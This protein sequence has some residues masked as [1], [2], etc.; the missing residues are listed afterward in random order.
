MSKIDKPSKSRQSIPLRT[1]IKVSVDLLDLDD[2]NPRLTDMEVRGS[3]EK[4]IA[5][6]YR[7][8]DLNELL[9]SI[10]ANGYT[11]IEPFIV[12]ENNDRYIVLEGNRRLA[13]VRL[14]RDPGLSN[15]VFE[16]TGIRIRVPEIPQRYKD[17]L[18]QISVYRVTERKDADSFIGFKHING[19]ARWSSY[20]KAKFA[21]RW[22]KE[23]DLSLSEIANQIGD[24]HATVKRMVHAIHILEQAEAKSLFDIEDRWNPSFSFSHLYTA[25]SRS[26]YRKFLGLDPNWASYEPKPNPVP[27]ENEQFLTELLIW[28]YGSNQNDIN[29]VVKSQNPDIKRL[30][31]VLNNTA[32]LTVLRAGRPLDEAHESTLPASQKFAESLILLRVKIREAFQSV[33]GFDGQDTS[34]IDVAEEISETALAIQDRMKKKMTNISKTIND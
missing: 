20:A 18:E 8:E 15:R 34:L 33:R 3:E 6:L 13:T 22:Y 31:E 29:P 17:T 10:T 21:A 9:H 24:R 19:A 26:D 16:A 30:G 28:I 11:D 1:V 14:L 12:C 23:N 2:H 25:L 4:I 5:E 7:T 27:E 32:S